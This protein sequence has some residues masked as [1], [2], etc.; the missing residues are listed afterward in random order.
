[1]VEVA[2][3]GLRS[4]GLA[5]EVDV[6]DAL[7][8]RIGAD[9]L[10]GLAL[11][12]G[13]NI[14]LDERTDRSL[15]EV[16][17]EVEG[18]LAGIG[19]TLLL[20]LQDAV[21]AD[22]GQVG[23]LQ[24]SVARVVVVDSAGQRVAESGLGRETLVL[25][26]LSH[27]GHRGLI[28]V[29]VLADSGE[30]EVDKLHQRLDILR[31]G[32]AA[33]V[34]VILA[35]TYADVGLL[36]EEGLLQLVVREVAQTA[37]AHHEVEALEVVVVG[38][39]IEALAATGH[40]LELD[41][42]VLVVGLLQDDAGTIGERQLLVAKLRVLLLLDDLASLRQ[43]GLVEQRLVLHVVLVGLELL[44]AHT[45]DGLLHLGLGGVDLAVLLLLI[46]RDDEVGIVVGDEVLGILVDH[47]D[48]QHRD[49][50]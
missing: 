7:G 15:V 36:A 39:A 43:L 38:L 46:E 37:G 8:D 24:R 34:L 20:D 32:E 11:R 18:K 30:V 49:E 3:H 35:E 26:R 42:V 50:L 17:D 6:D 31:D 40:G 27:H 1:M 4:L 2:G 13:A 33:E 44:S 10:R 28:L 22:V 19:E 29:L 45:V 41:L 47:I 23:L 9:P 16:A 25:Q 5:L 21:V 48:G 12:Q 14:L